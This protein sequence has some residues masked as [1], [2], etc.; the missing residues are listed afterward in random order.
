MLAVDTNILVRALVRDDP[1]Q[2]ARAQTI[3]ETEEVWIAKTVLLETNWVLG[4]I[5]RTT[6]EQIRNGLSG[7]VGLPNVQIEDEAA[8]KEAL[9][10][11]EGGLDFAD[12][13]HLASRP[14]SATFVSFDEMLV[15]RAQRAGVPAVKL[16]GKKTIN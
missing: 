2:T 14:Q 15:R 6:A 9:R 11:F 5:Y 8:V 16:G 4:K 13:L 10:L 3:L 7:L 1:V 12:A